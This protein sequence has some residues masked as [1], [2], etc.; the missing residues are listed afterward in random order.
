MKTNTKRN[1]AKGFWPVLLLSA[2]LSLPAAGVAAPSAHGKA[3]AADKANKNHQKQQKVQQFLET[4]K[5]GD[6]VITTG[7]IYGQVT[8]L[9]GSAARSG[10]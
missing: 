3:H 4:L 6:R 5:V 7:G 10:S 1:L 8:R 9:G 2:A